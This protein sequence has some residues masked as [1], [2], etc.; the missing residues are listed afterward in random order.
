M[1]TPDIQGVLALLD[2]NDKSVRTAILDHLVRAGL[3]FGACV[4]AFSEY[5][6][7]AK[8]DAYIAAAQQQ[9]GR[10]GE[11]EVDESAYVSKGDDPG[12]YVMAWVWVSDDDAGIGDDEE[13][14]VSGS[15]VDLYEKA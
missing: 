11:I 6:H 14:G 2:L 15:P 7:D 1:T 4:L 10:E 13:T 5:E 9:Y 3:T 12:A 8:K